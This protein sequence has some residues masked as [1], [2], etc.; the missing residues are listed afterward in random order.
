M[1][2]LTIPYLDSFWATLA[3]L[4]YPLTWLLIPWV[5]LKPVVHPSSRIAWILGILFVPYIGALTALVFGVNHV[6]RH[7]IGKQ[8]AKQ[9][10]DEQLPDPPDVGPPDVP[11]HLAD[12]YRLAQRMGHEPL[13]PGND[14]QLLP[15][16]QEAFKHIEAVIRGAQQSLSIAFYIWRSDR[17]G[18]QLR[19]AIIDRAQ[20]GVKVRF[21]YDGIGSMWLSDR[22]L[23]P[24]T[25]AG[26][27][28]A[29]FLPGRYF[30][31]RWSI[32]LRSHRKI[33]VADGRVGFTGGMNIGDEYL[34]RSAAY[35]YWR[36][37]QIQV[38]GPAASRLQQIFAADWYY[39]TGEALTD[40][41]LFPIDEHQGTAAVQV[42]SDGPDRVE[43]LFHTL[44]F[45]AISNARQQ[46]TLSTGY[47][48][49]TDSLLD[50][51]SSAAR[52]GVK[53]RLLTAGKN[54][55]FYTLLA[56][57][58]YYAELLEAGAEVY[59]Y[60]KGLFHAKVV[61]IDRRWWLVGTPNLDMRS[62]TL[63]FEN[64][65]TGF[66]PEVADALERQFEADLPDACQIDAA[67]WSDRGNWRR[68]GE[69]F[70]RLFAPVL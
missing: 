13:V 6:K 26:V 47:F 56:G 36:D 64:A 30:W 32:N 37:T 57:R 66:A 4:A 7:A 46:V 19:D 34:G 58:A 53:V 27:Q 68:L 48:V 51:M 24:M 39:A 35:G 69:E 5:L 49:P 29:R 3:V 10:I 17:I 55:Y 1:F 50:A 67:T 63:N 8:K 60:Q 20:A 41:A 18:T 21:L 43:S 2:A 44:L 31:A 70:C 9:R 11:Q 28:V 22:F 45:T 23:K 38:R 14:I 12:L 15:E 42:L 59:E 33:V 61:V 25:D 65:V 40:P 54:T 62:L 16:T 52:R